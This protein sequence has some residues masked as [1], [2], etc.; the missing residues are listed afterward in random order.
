VPSSSTHYSFDIPT[1]GSDSTTYGTILNQFVN[2]LS[3]K[4]KTVSDKI[5]TAGVGAS[6]TL[7]RINNYI[8]QVDNINNRLPNGVANLLPDPYSGALTPV[9][10]WPFLNTE[11]QAEGYSPPTTAQEVL[12]FDYSGFAAYLNTRFD[13]LAARVLGLDAAVSIHDTDQLVCEANT[14]LDAIGTYKTVPE[15]VTTLV[16]KVIPYRPVVH[17]GSPLY[18]A[19]W[20]YAAGKP[21]EGPTTDNTVLLNIIRD[22]GYPSGGMP[23]ADYYNNQYRFSLTNGPSVTATFQ[24]LD[25]YSAVANNE[26]IDEGV[27]LHDTGM[28]GS[29]TFTFTH[30]DMAYTN[31]GA[32]DLSFWQGGNNGAETYSNPSISISSSFYT[33][34]FVKVAEVLDTVTQDTQV[35]IGINDI[36]LSG[37]A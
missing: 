3:T 22:V 29:A 27:Y 37:C 28:T 17:L 1:V 32:S 15:T 35:K 25:V 6:S 33:L 11:L 16:K 31:P 24:I 10:T 14:I 36:D 13:S 21:D 9:S 19:A 4:L 7:A 34:R 8:S 23:T 5:N 18:G 2:S 12:D 26:P 30:Y 20:L